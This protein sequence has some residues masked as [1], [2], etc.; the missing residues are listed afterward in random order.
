MPNH[1]QNN[2]AF[3]TVYADV[4]YAFESFKIG[5][6]YEQ[7]ALV[8]LN[9]GFIETLF[10]AKNDFNTFL[11]LDT[12]NT[13]LRDVTLEGS[14][15]Y[16]KTKGMYIQKI[17]SVQH[18]HFI[19]L[20]AKLLLSDEIQDIKLDGSNTQAR[21]EA[22]FD[23]YYR[24]KNYVSHNEGGSDSSYGYGY[25]FDLEYI[26]NNEALYIYAGLLNIGATLY[27][28]GINKMHYDFDSKTIYL[29][30][31]GYNHRK[32]FGVGYYKYDINYKQDLPMFYRG[33]LNYEF[34]TIVSLGAN[35]NGYKEYYFNELYC[36]IKLYNTR[37]K[38]GYINEASTLIFGA[39]F[40]HFNVE[41]SNNFSFSQQVMQAKID[42]WF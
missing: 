17:F 10:Y 13:Q 29:G 1:T 39:Y 35:L 27:W 15:N 7:T 30:K 11:H 21:F 26:Y 19:S 16:Y 33:S 32:P 3:G 40:D 23:Y 6:F 31:D 9:D 41:I 4:Y 5:A 20:K 14:A 38:V 22:G 42:F 18:T 24:T 37:W 8:E 34:N 2:I 28:D 36:N 12:I 25:G